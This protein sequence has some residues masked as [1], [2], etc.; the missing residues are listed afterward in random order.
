VFTGE[1]SK[2]LVWVG[3]VL[4]ELLDDILADVGVVLLDLFRTT[5]SIA[6]SSDNL[7]SE[8]VL[9]GDLSSLSTVSQELL[10]KAGDI[11]SG[12]RDVLDRG[13]NNVSLG[14]YYQRQS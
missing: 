11:S 6:L 12:D 3:V 7:H 13:S 10:H 5:V 4:L 9:W 8:L 14:L 2:V 1:S